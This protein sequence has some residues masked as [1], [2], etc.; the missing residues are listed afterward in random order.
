VLRVYHET[1]LLE[2]AES[3]DAIRDHTLLPGLLYGA[4]LQTRIGYV[5]LLNMFDGKTSVNRCSIFDEHNDSPLDIP[6][7][8]ISLPGLAIEVRP[9]SRLSLQLVS[10]PRSVE[11]DNN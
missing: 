3:E 9:R 4:E 2:T 1:K 10:G 6:F 8:Q 7:Q 5:L 11:Q